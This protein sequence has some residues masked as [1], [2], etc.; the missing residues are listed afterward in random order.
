[1]FG[2][3]GAGFAIPAG[4]SG[5]PTGSG[6]S[7][8]SNSYSLEFSGVN[9][10]VN[11]GK[12]SDL[13]FDVSTDSF[14][15]SA[16]I[17]RPEA[18]DFQRCV[19]SKAEMNGGIITAFLGVNTDGTV[20]VL[21]GG[22]EN[23]SG[24]DVT[25]MGWHLLTVTCS[26]GQGRLFLDGTQ[27][28]SAFSTG[29]GVNTA[30]DWLLGAARY[31]NNSDDSYPYRGYLDE[32]TFWDSA[33]SLPQIV[34][35]YNSGTP[36]DPTTHAEAAH[37]LHWYRM[38][39]GDS[40]PAITDQQGSSDGIATNTAAVRLV[41]LSPTHSPSTLDTY[42]LTDPDIDM[43]FDAGDHPGTA[44]DWVDQTANWTANIDAGSGS[45][46]KTET[47]Q[48]PGFYEL[49]T[50]RLFR[51]ASDAA[52]AVT[53]NCEFTYTIRMYTG[54]LD[55][56]GGFYTGYDGHFDGYSGFQIYNLFYAEDVGV[57]IRKPDDSGDNWAV[58]EHTS[59]HANKYVMI[60]VTVKVVAGVATVRA[61]SLGGKLGEDTS[62]SGT[63][64]PVASAPLG[65]C[66][67]A[68]TG[69]G[70]YHSTANGQKYMSCL[71]YQRELTEGEIAL[72]S[73]RFNAVKGY[74]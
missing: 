10:Y 45:P 2:L 15:I 18:P 46:T 25:D 8:V 42:S 33:L 35:L 14:T 40:L 7:A 73:A 21:L 71:R 43:Y 19:L 1:M 74:I 49:T 55:G 64:T 27:V 39:D 12:P 65:L 31:N 26:S 11:I 37:L 63:F 41:E 13:D 60:A 24:G 44:S 17:R 28:G 38:G 69:G 6:P 34:Q 54:A 9:G 47:S 30:S 48:F 62:L 3:S 50:N 57:R 53:S 66:G 16:W 23:T 20:Y 68:Y 70:G 67:N 51:V 29:T 58:E 72:L 32:V 5:T 56:S 52:N 61:Y 36:I 4:R 22:G 59:A